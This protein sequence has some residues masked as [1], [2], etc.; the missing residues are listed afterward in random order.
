MLPSQLSG[1]VTFAGKKRK[2]PF[3]VLKDIMFATPVTAGINLPDA[4][5]VRCSYSPRNQQCAQN[6]CPYYSKL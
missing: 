1:P 4:E 2:L 5:K 6:K 3:I